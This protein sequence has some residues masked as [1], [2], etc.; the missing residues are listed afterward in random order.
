MTAAPRLRRGAAVPGYQPGTFE[1]R[2][3][4][5]DR[6]HDTKTGLI[7]CRERGD[8]PTAVQELQPDPSRLVAG[9]NS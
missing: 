9:V 6:M 1:Q 3:V 8:H 5:A 2:D 4:W 7:H